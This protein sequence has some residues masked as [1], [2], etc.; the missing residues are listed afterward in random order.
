MLA[1]L[2]CTQIKI[3]KKSNARILFV[4]ILRIR[5]HCMYKSVGHKANEL[6]EW[7]ERERVW[8]LG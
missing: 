7:E 2:I 6:I 8:R 5:R 3:K 4:E 1:K